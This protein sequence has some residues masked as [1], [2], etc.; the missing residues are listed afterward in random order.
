MR[1]VKQGQVVSDT[2]QRVLDDAPIPDDGAVIVPAARLLADA[3][4][5]IARGAELGVL[6][7]NDRKISELEPYLGKIA[8][9]ALVF[10]NFKDGRAYSQA[11]ILRERYQFR[12]ELRATGQVLRDQ[13]L[14]LLRAGFDSFEVT[15]EA[16]A[17]AFKDAIRRYS[18]FYQP[19]ADGQLPAFRRRVVARKPEG[20]FCPVENAQ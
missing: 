19:A 3:G 4:E 7:P 15:K 5:L 10:P 18:V 16:D 6:W 1:L 14:F 8:L 11:R 17:Q 9:V 20:Q 12:G 2:Y 13:F